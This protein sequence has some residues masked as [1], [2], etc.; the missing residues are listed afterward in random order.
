MKPRKRK[1]SEKFRRV[2]K[3]AA[4]E[5]EFIS[6]L[7]RP[8]T[9][10][11]RELA[12][13]RSE[14]VKRAPRQNPPGHAMPL[15][16]PKF[17]QTVYQDLGPRFQTTRIRH[18]RHRPLPTWVLA[19]YK[20]FLLHEFPSQKITDWS[21]L[22]KSQRRKCERDRH[23]AQRWGVVL[24]EYFSGGKSQTDIEQSHRWKPGTVRW[25]VQDI[26]AAVKGRRRD[27][28]D[29]TSGKAGRPKKKAVEN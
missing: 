9:A 20:A 21:N 22:S 4:S 13:I 14:K 19:S 28:R 18:L 25:I 1:K 27:G 16:P 23:S 10:E 3:T 2:C 26:R 15:N 5:P 8:L 29:R 7:S 6:P 17:A 11:E 24:T 12:L